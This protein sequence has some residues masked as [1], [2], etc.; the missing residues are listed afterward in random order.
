MISNEPTQL[1]AEWSNIERKYRGG[2]LLGYNIRFKK[3]LEKEFKMIVVNIGFLSRTLTNLMPFTLYLVEISGFN[4]A[5][6]GPPEYAV[7]ETQQ[8]GKCSSFFVGLF[9]AFLFFTDVFLKL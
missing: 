9:N 8:G 5:G 3:Y 4:S 7:V 2:E 1:F 6:E